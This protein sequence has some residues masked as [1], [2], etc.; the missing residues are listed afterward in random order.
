MSR[1]QLSIDLE[2]F[3]GYQAPVPTDAFVIGIR[4]RAPLQRWP[5]RACD[6]NGSDFSDLSSWPNS[7]VAPI[8]VCSR[9][10]PRELPY[11]PQEDPEAQRRAL[12]ARPRRPHSSE[13]RVTVIKGEDS[14]NSETSTLGTNADDAELQRRGGPRR[15]LEAN[16]DQL[17]RE[18][19]EAQ[20]M[21][22]QQQQLIAMLT[23]RL[24]DMDARFQS[25]VTELTA[26]LE[27]VNVNVGEK[28]DSIYSKMSET[29]V[30]RAAEVSR[31][32][33]E[34]R[35]LKTSNAEEF[36]S[37]RDSI[38][39]CRA[40]LAKLE[41]RLEG[42]LSRPPPPSVVAPPSPSLTSPSSVPS[43]QPSSSPSAFKPS[44]G[45][46]GGLSSFSA[47]VPSG[48]ASS[49]SP[50]FP[51][52]AT[53]G[54]G[55]GSGISTTTRNG[56]G[57]SSFD[58]KTAE[59]APTA[60]GAPNPT[61]DDA[62]AL[63]KSTSTK[64]V[65]LESPFAAQS[66]DASKSSNPFSFEG[67][68]NRSAVAATKLQEAASDNP[69]TSISMGTFGGVGRTFPAAANAAL[70]AGEVK[71]S[72]FG[73]SV[74]G[75]SQGA[76]APAPSGTTSIG[77]SFQT[78]AAAPPA[79]GTSATTNG[80]G[81]ATASPAT[82]R[83]SPFSF[84]T[85]G[86]TAVSMTAGGNPF[87]PATS[88]S[89]GP[90]PSPFGC[91]PMSQQAPPPANGGASAASAPATATSSFDLSNPSARAPASSG[92]HSGSR[93]SSSGRGFGGVAF[94]ASTT[95]STGVQMTPAASFS[96]GT[97]QAH[98][99]SAPPVAFTSAVGASS[100]SSTVPTSGPSSSG[101]AP[102]FGLNTAGNSGSNTS[103]GGTGAFGSSAFPSTGAF[104]FS[105]TT[106][107]P[108]PF[109]GPFGGGGSGA[110]TPA[111]AAPAFGGSS[112]GASSSSFSFGGAPTTAT[113]DTA[114]ALGTNVN[115][116]KPPVSAPF[117]GGGFNTN[118]NAFG[119]AADPK[120]ASPNAFSGPSSAA[121]AGGSSSMVG[122]SGG[123]VGSNPVSGSAA[124]T[125]FGASMNINN[126]ASNSVFGS[127][128]GG[129]AGAF[130]GEAFGA[131]P[132]RGPAP[133]FGSSPAGESGPSRSAF[134]AAPPAFSQPLSSSP[135]FGGGAAATGV[136]GGSSHGTSILGSSSRKK[137]PRRY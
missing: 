29:M 48:N 8:G 114:G 16:R 57:A 88:D 32:E 68:L 56:F 10:R 132:A 110:L 46:F 34:L 69:A 42:V 64:A 55:L 63:T 83:P 12:V 74:A 126:N 30:A 50:P 25:Q 73:G 26:K 131:A 36:K 37:C 90:T 45:A 49:S 120:A 71:P 127:G 66:V 96:F 79:Q 123:G 116:P 99:P 61:A 112:N 41:G 84:N 115:Q 117:G 7:V 76:G 65:A 11:E 33:Q 95:P 87:M 44:G 13:S 3:L 97:T 75:A 1:S 85:A 92:G 94:P 107:G 118:T 130:G 70:S 103:G 67:S 109:G 135:V 121:G 54:A 15:R 58:A 72:V 129:A 106:S 6:D 82:P 86:V 35:A 27:E 137:A 136:R 81:V 133:V 38:V 77:F 24:D 14:A 18:F 39:A 43:A 31:L 22:R 23:S 52:A 91:A 4:P 62:A 108:T 124:S 102:A 100:A 89:S 40:D 111:C 59:S 122:G 47:A 134:G 53:V 101:T 20:N 128:G 2:D 51:T 60:T 19:S 28:Y 17:S 119:A 5:K 21:E 104:P 93:R 125:P 80:F 98:E 105:S 9:R 113:R 78:K